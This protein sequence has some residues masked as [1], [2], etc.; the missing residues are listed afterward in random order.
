MYLTTYL[1]ILNYI[2][3]SLSA[4]VTWL[5]NTSFNLPTNFK[6]GKLP[7]SKETV[8]FPESLTSSIRIEAGTS[9]GGFVLPLDG[10]LILTE[11]TIEFGPTRDDN[12]SRYGNSYY[13]EKSLSFWAQPDVWSSSKFNKA[14]PDAERV[15]CFDDIVEFPTNTDFTVVLP[16]DTQK[17]RGIIL[18]GESFDTKKFRDYV[19]NQADQTQQFILNEN[20]DTG[21]VVGRGYCTS[22]A[23]CPCQDNVLEIDCSA[24]FC[25]I[26]SCVDPIQP[27]GHCC[28]ICGGVIA[29]E[30]DRSFDI[31]E[32]KEKVGKAIDSYDGS[33]IYHV[34]RLPNKVQLVVVEK[35]EYTGTSAEVV[36]D[37]AYNLENHIVHQLEISGS[38]LYKSGLGGKIFVSMFFAVA[39]VMVAIYIYYYRL[40]EIRFP[41]MARS[42]PSLF[43]R[44]DR[45]TESVVSLTR[46][47]SVAPMGSSIAT[48]FR[49]PL[50]DS[51][52]K[53]LVDESLT[54]E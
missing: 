1:I 5:P 46:R 20:E 10:E 44:F 29:F 14:T 28:K 54:E 18:N 17:V 21:V 37:I 38:P 32:F 42:Q 51:K 33:L 11:G 8:I 50:Y 13:T 3:I 52:R 25:P 48:A 15:P 16:D 34:G 40:P 53:H 47:D 41:I 19:I 26:P 27:I 6:N 7:C 36:N 31:T 12:C 23:G 2:S 30:I 35:D 4:K 43:S 24:K 22:P 9:V 39:L 49:N 45:R